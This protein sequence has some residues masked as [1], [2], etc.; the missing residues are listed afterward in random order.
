MGLF[1]PV[2]RATH[3]Y[4]IVEETKDLP[5]TPAAPVR[6][7]EATGCREWPPRQ[8]GSSIRVQ[9]LCVHALQVWILQYR[10]SKIHQ[11][12]PEWHRLQCHCISVLSLLIILK[13][14]AQ[15]F[16]KAI[17]LLKTGC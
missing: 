6:K 11:W 1:L 13:T 15:W 10:H 2:M 4:V 14:W 5:N 9:A 17:L 8:A 3:Q 12:G 7:R 16:A